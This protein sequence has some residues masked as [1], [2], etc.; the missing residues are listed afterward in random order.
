MRLAPIVLGVTFLTASVIA[1][2]S[3]DTSSSS[4]SSSSSGGSSSGGSSSG[5]SSSGG[6]SSGG[7]SSGGSSSGDAGSEAGAALN[8]CTSYED[9]TADNA[10]RVI[11]WDTSVTSLPE[12]CMKIKAGQKVIFST[13]TDAA[14][15]PANFGVHP[16]KASGGDTP[17]PFDTVDDASGAVT[18]AAAGTFGYKCNVHSFMTG[19][20]EVV[21]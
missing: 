5:G 10:S 9:R 2:S 3:S 11:K 4:S 19:A 17:N 15:A 18:F 21:Q 14:G 20:I 7:S 1:C 12:H 13:T 16:L 8:G 6:S